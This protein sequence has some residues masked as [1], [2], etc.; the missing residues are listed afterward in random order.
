MVCLPLVL[1]P[2]P[3]PLLQVAD[4]CHLATSDQVATGGDG[5]DPPL[6]STSTEA[7]RANL[8]IAGTETFVGL[9]KPVWGKEPSQ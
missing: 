6:V 4:E 8:T 3:G 2:L 9:G 1:L 7:Q 5:W